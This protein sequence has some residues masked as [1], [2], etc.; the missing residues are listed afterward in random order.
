MAG[1][2]ATTRRLRGW[3]QLSPT[4]GK[5]AGASRI[6]R[7]MTNETADRSTTLA[8]NL[9]LLTGRVASAHVGKQVI[10]EIELVPN[11]VST[12]RR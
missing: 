7:I 8:T 9:P 11:E 10:N 12:R 6:W 1:A 3:R 2:L 4:L 5:R